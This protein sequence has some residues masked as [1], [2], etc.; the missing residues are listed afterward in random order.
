MPNYHK[1][2]RC[3]ILPSLHIEP[4]TDS[5]APNEMTDD[6]LEHFA[7]L[8]NL[9]HLKIAD[10]RF[11]GS[12]LRFL[13]ECDKLEH[14]ILDGVPLEDA[15]ITRHRSE[16][17]EAETVFVLRDQAY[18][19]RLDGVGQI[20]AVEGCPAC[21]TE[22]PTMLLAFSKRERL[23]RASTASKAMLERFE[24]AQ[25]EYAG[26]TDQAADPTEANERGDE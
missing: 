9:V 4:N 22:I 7:S 26:D 14:L 8:T 2:N 3:P 18:G 21:L 5:N 15:A 23:E 16:F 12:G 10:M 19:R 6:V 25:R 17:S 11:D 20:A 24:A 1:Y 13:K